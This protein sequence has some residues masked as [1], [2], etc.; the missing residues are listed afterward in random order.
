MAKDDK[1]PQKWGSE[2]APAMARQGLREV[3]A[4]FFPESNVAQQPEYGVWGT[5]TPGEVAE[6]RRS[7]GH[8]LEDERSKDGHSILGDRLRQAEGRDGRGRDDKTLDRDR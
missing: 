5:K 8:D 2:H 1:T 4:A 6:D 3:R 7:D